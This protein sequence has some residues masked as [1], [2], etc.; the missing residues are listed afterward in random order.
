MK[1]HLSKA[2]RKLNMTAGFT[3]VEMLTAILILLMVSSVVAAGIPAAINAYEKVVIASNAEVLLSTTITALRNELGTADEVTV[4][5]ADGSN[6]DPAPGE[7]ISYRS[8]ATG[9]KAKLHLDPVESGK[10]EKTIKLKRYA[11]VADSEEVWLISR[12]AS[13]AD[14]YVTYDSVS[15]DKDTGVVTFSNLRVMRESAS[16]ELTKRETYSIK[17][18]GRSI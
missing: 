6:A 17:V 11:E 5:N 15:Y 18:I 14:L 16:Q 3:L 2:G 8:S 1:G 10:T 13:T 9:A 12:Q 7:G 4:L